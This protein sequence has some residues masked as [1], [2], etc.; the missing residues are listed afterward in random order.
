MDAVNLMGR[1]IKSAAEM[2]ANADGIA[3]ADLRGPV[4]EFKIWAWRHPY[5]LADEIVVGATKLISDFHLNNI[6]ARLFENVG[7]VRA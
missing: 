4:A 5:P 1:M 3:C 2:S 6:S 7:N